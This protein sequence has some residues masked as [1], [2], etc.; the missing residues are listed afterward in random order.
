MFTNLTTHTTYIVTLYTAVTVAA[1]TYSSTPSTQ[2][3]T[4]LSAPPSAVQS[5]TT[6]STN[7]SITIS[8]SS[9]ITT[10]NDLATYTVWWTSLTGCNNPSNCGTMNVPANQTS[11][12][13]PNTGTLTSCQNFAIAVAAT[14]GSPGGGMGRNGTTNA[15]TL[16]NSKLR[17]CCYWY[18]MAARRDCG[19]W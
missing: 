5:L 12:T 18:V 16:A 11:F 6:S 14:T 1:Q 13:V 15:I 9:P 19:K 10:Y 8:W 2:S 17:M 4:T 7:T 3:T